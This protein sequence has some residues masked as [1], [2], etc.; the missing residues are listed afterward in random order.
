MPCTNIR[1]QHY[2]YKG[3]EIPKV[4]ETRSMEYQLVRTE[5]R[6][7]DALAVRSQSSRGLEYN[8]D[9]FVTISTCNEPLEIKFLYSEE[10]RTT[11]CV[12]ASWLL[13]GRTHYGREGLLICCFVAHPRESNWLRLSLLWVVNSL[14]LCAQRI[15]GG[16]C[17][18][19]VPTPWS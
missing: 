11:S 12:E 16:I 2:R 17:F 18:A 15:G 14:I 7:A 6:L 1:K 4:K 3:C 10:P 9:K 13:I 8:V 5:N 19:F